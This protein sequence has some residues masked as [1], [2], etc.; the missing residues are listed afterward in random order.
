M[1]HARLRWFFSALVS[2]RGAIVGMSVVVGVGLAGAAFA[3]SPPAALQPTMPSG[4]QPSTQIDGPVLRFDWPAIEVGVASYEA[5]PTGV[6][7]FRFPKR[8]AAAVDVR[9]GAPG[10]VNTDALRLGADAPFLDA[11]VFTG[12]SMY[13]EGAITGT[14]NA[15]ADLGVHGTKWGDIAVVTGAVIYDFEGHRLNEIHPDEALA[16]AAVQSLRPGVFPLG[17]QGAGRMAMQGGFFGCDAHSGQ[18]GAVRTHGKVKIAAFVVVNASGSVTDRAGNIVKCHRNPL[19]PDESSVS[20]LLARIGT[21]TLLTDAG[22]AAGPTHNTTL[23]LVVTNRRMNMYE[24]QR[25]AVQAHTS[26]A[27]AIQPFSTEDDGDTLFAVSTEELPADA[28]GLSD[29]QIDT[30]AGEA[31][32]DAV[33]ASVPDEADVPLGAGKSG[34]ASLAG[35]AQV[36]VPAHPAEPARLAKQELA[37]VSGRYRFGP[38]AL[39]QFSPSGGV[40]M[41]RS[42]AS[43]FFDIPHDKP[44]VLTARS[45]TQFYI[46]GR[47]RTRVEFIIGPDGTATEAIINPGRWAQ[48]GLRIA[49]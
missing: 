4:P 12:G 21:G 26:M 10:T 29:V 31:L 45:A 36:M 1:R 47:Y 32:W 35:P 5:G 16:R 23:S 18:G 34:P 41:L 25:L 2:V 37:R 44:V 48:H 6:T 42:D 46:E 11:L 28:S 27:R 15:L 7:V 9:G 49:P 14:A 17:A 3:E 8:A 38:H 39:L 40:L 13:G 19:W 24:L 30:L 22:A 43:R 20:R 33:L